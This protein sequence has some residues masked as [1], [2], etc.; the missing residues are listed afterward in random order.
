M[1]VEDRLKT[2]NRS[3]VLGSYT[4]A[5]SE[6]FIRY[7]SGDRKATSEY[8]Y[9]NQKEDAMAIVGEFYHNKRRVVS[10]TKKTKVGADG[11]MIELAK[12]MTTHPDD[13]FVIN[14]A[15]VRILTG[16]SNAGWEKDMK[17][18]APYCF[19]DKI[20]HHG[21]LKH[22]DLR[23]LTNSLIIIDELDNG[24][25]ERQV[26]HNTLKAAGALDIQYLEENNVRFVFISATMIKE[27]YELYRWG[28][29]HCLYKMTIPESYIGHTEFLERGVIQ[30]FYSLNTDASATKW[31]Q[32]DIL[33]NYGPD[34]RIHIVRANQ[35]T[36]IA[37]QNACIQNGIDYRN[38]T[39]SDKIDESVLSDLFEGALTRHVVLI[40]KGF[41]RRANLIPNQWK[42]RIGAT[43]ELY[44][45]I[46]DNNAQIQAL[47]GRMTG[48]W[49]GAIESGHKTGPYRTSV[50]AVEEYEAIYNNPFG[51]NSYQAAGF[52]KNN[53]HVSTITPTLVTPKNVAGLVPVDLPSN[54][55]SDTDDSGEFERGHGVFDTQAENE[56]YAKKCGAQRISSYDSNDAGFKMC[57]TTSRRVHSLD[58]ILKFTKTSNKGSNLDKKLSD[59][60]VGEFAYR[61]YVCYRDITDKSSECFVTI[62][63]KRIIAAEE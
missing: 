20:F 52:K 62:W 8:I 15:N 25:K 56:A 63:V 18:K 41:F 36:A 23:G 19:K 35:K 24:D 6:N 11:L 31:V 3:L 49:R 37:I 60:K 48:Y 33:D 55:D 27:L 29:H 28:E 42:L 10:I 54:T 59:L 17:D 32:E 51:V 39:S 1:N 40:V 12:Q 22:S 50:K 26:L 16:M 21:Q 45:K 61:R 13:D 14:P 57:S 58:D 2:A 53:G 4:A 38:H 7:S 30:E 34:F 9:D 47:P 44:T 43:H 46:V 5:V